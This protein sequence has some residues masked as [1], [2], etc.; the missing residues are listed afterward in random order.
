MTERDEKLEQELQFLDDL[1]GQI[2]TLQEETNKHFDK[3]LFDVSHHTA[4]KALN[5]VKQL[6]STSDNRSLS[7]EASDIVRGTCDQLTSE[8]LSIRALS[9]INIDKSKLSQSLSQQLIDSI[10]ADLQQ[11]IQIYPS[12]VSHLNYGAFLYSQSEF[13]RALEEYE[14]AIQIDP[15]KPDAYLEKGLCLS[16]Q[17]AKTI[18]PS[19]SASTQ[20]IDKIKSERGNISQHIETIYNCATI[21]IENDH[22]TSNAHFLRGLWIAENDMSGRKCTGEK[23]KLTNAISDLTKHIDSFP[24]GPLPF[25][26]RAYCHRQL[27]NMEEAKKDLQRCEESNKEHNVFS[28]ED[29]AQ[30]HRLVSIH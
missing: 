26:Y 20:P 16:S 5:L 1:Y 19:A 12:Y 24:F 2:I 10:H 6:L 3:G 7:K 11:V 21:A 13:E 17:L 8:L 14:R 29:L 30:I 22:R 15:H 4:S 23:W 28:E 25:I 9:A 18:R 27:G